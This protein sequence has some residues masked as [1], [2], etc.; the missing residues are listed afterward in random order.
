MSFS[1]WRRERVRCWEPTER[2]Y[3]RITPN[4][5]FSIPWFGGKR[6]RYA[7]HHGLQLVKWVGHRYYVE[8]QLLGRSRVRGEEYV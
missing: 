1:E 3:I 2:F 5:G 4:F 8:K 7:R 6:I